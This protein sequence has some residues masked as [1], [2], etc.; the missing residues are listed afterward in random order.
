M[1]DETGFGFY[2]QPAFNPAI[3]DLFDRRDQMGVRTFVNTIETLANPP[4][5]RS[6]SAPSTTSRSRRRW[7]TRS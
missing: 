3:D 5:R 4:G 1:V 7:S 6:T 2:Y